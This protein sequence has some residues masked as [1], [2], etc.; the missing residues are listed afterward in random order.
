MNNY[1]F[2]PKKSSRMGGGGIGAS[3]LKQR[4]AMYPERFAVGSYA[5]VKGAK[6][7]ELYPFTKPYISRIEGGQLTLKQGK[8]KPVT[9]E[10]KERADGQE[11]AELTQSGVEANKTFEVVPF[12]PDGV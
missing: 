6:Q 4:P 11:Y 1:H 8:H 10:L 7:I 2:T 3:M 12:N 5:L 9:I